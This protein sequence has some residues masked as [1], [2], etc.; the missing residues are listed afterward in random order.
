MLFFFFCQKNS[1]NWKM[2]IKYNQ[3]Q[4][5]C[6]GY[7]QKN[8]HELLYITLWHTVYGNSTMDFHCGYTIS[9][10]IF[11][12]IPSPFTIISTFSSKVQSSKFK[13]RS[14][15]I[16]ASRVS[17]RIF[18]FFHKKHHHILS[19]NVRKSYPDISHRRVSLLQ[20]RYS[21]LASPC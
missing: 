10:T 17:R 9:Y 7:E 18:F 20:S 11:S 15:Q 1:R 21:S 12:Y 13:K 8:S 5:V 4:I 14:L 19:D 6:T 3:N 2:L 16:I